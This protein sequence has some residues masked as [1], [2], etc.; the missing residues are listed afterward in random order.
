MLIIT[1][2][3]TGHEDN[4]FTPVK[5]TP[6]P[7]GPSSAPRL[8]PHP[9]PRRPI[10]P[11]NNAV[12]ENDDDLYLQRADAGDRRVSQDL[13]RYGLMARHSTVYSIVSRAHVTAN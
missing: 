10:T 7:L 4:N 9:K 11:V 3:L 8:A 2:W 13:L 6:I 5:P 1:V 12:T